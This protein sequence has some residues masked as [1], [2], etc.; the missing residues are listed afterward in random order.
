MVF[1]LEKRW[2]DMDTENPLPYSQLKQK[3]WIQQQTQSTHY[4]FYKRRN[5][6]KL[7]IWLRIT[8]LRDIKENNQQMKWYG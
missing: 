6:R 4:S 8:T 7:S 2:V 3:Y 1:A 5:E